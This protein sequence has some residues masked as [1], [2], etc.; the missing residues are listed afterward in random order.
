M[1]PHA[2]DDT[3]RL[4]QRR[5]PPSRVLVA[6]VAGLVGVLLGG[7]ALW[8]FI[9]RPPPPHPPIQAPAVPAAPAPAAPVPAAPAVPTPPGATAPAVPAA[10]AFPI[11]T[12]TEAEIRDHSATTLTVFRF[13][14]NPDVIVMDFPT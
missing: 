12:A 4:N 5:A 2:D 1:A 10:P 3:V 7:T 11:Q 13:A 6:A 14:P 9:P 8:V